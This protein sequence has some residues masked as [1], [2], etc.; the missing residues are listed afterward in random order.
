MATLRRGTR[1]AAIRRRRLPRTAGA[2]GAPILWAGDQRPVNADQVRPPNSRAPGYLTPPAPLN[3]DYAPGY[4]IPAS[5]P[6]K[7]RAGGGLIKRAKSQWSQA[8]LER[9]AELIEASPPGRRPPI[10]K[11]YEQVAREREL[12][13]LFA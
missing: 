1:K 3:P 12:R 5:P 6:G 7:A 4:L 11:I 2:S 10:E 8:E 9:I 13:R